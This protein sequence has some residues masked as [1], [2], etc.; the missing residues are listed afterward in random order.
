MHDKHPCLMYLAQKEKRRSKPKWDAQN[1]N[2][3]Q[4]ATK[5]T[6]KRKTRRQTKK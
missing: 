5:I 3:V 4:H 1:F 2:V 6:K